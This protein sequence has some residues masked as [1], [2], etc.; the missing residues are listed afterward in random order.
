LEKKVHAAH[1]VHLEIKELL[2]Y[3]VHKV[4]V[5]QSVH[6]VNKVLLG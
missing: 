3:L 5:E 2:V 6:K 4:T 1:K